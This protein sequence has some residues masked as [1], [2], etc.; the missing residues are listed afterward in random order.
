MK[1]MGWQSRVAQAQKDW[2]IKGKKLFLAL[3]ASSPVVHFRSCNLYIEAY[4]IAEAVLHR[5]D[6]S[7]Y[8]LRTPFLRHIPGPTSNMIQLRKSERMIVTINNQSSLRYWD[9]NW[10]LSMTNYSSSSLLL[11]LSEPFKKYDQ[12]ATWPLLRNSRLWDQT[13]FLWPHKYN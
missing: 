6:N 4:I 11:L 2:N 7:I 12:E 1:N 5:N 9:I 10:K 8:T 3:Y 13:L